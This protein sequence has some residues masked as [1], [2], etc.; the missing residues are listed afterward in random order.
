MRLTVLIGL[1]VLCLH[2]NSN[3]QSMNDKKN[4]NTNRI[5]NA[6]STPLRR[7]NTHSTIYFIP[8]ISFPSK[9][10]QEEISIL[11]LAGIIARIPR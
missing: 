9:K 7:S 4:K 2:Y 5:K 6:P 8:F 11:P 1:Q 10:P 3:G